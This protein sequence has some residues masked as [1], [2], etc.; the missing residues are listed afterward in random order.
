MIKM[1][2][3]FKQLLNVYHYV[4]KC[5]LAYYHLISYYNIFSVMSLI[6]IMCINLLIICIHFSILLNF[7]VQLLQ[8]ISNFPF[9][10]TDNLWTYLQ[11]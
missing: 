6:I 8:L 3:K 9:F 2:H 1:E 5:V 4:N 11:G 7:A 10:V